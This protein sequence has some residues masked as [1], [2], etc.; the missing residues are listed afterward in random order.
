[1]IE[2]FSA[3]FS[4]AISARQK[5]A[6]ISFFAILNAYVGRFAKRPYSKQTLGP[7]K[8]VRPDAFIGI[9]FSILT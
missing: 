4:S 7:P 9:C 2:S 3:A 8:M 1:M 5:A 6:S